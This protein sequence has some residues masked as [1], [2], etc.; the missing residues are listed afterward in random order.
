MSHT[1]HR[2]KKTL[3]KKITKKSNNFKD[4][5]DRNASYRKHRRVEDDIYGL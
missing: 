1:N 5:A 2:R 3:D 4:K